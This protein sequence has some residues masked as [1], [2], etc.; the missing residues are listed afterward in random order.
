M[1]IRGA[2]DLGIRR[3]RNED[4]HAW[5][6]AADQA[7]RARRGALMVVA[8]GMGGAKSGGVASQLAVETVIRTYQEAPGVDSPGTDVVAE[9]RQSVAEANRRVHSENLKSHELSGMA[10]T[11]TA[12]VVRGPE[13]Y[14]AH[15]GDSRAYVVRDGAAHQLTED[16]SFVGML[17]SQGQISKDEARVHPR[18]NLLTRS[19]GGAPEVVIDARRCE[20]VLAPGDTLVLC[21]DGLHGLVTD[22]ELAGAA[23]GQ[24]LDRVC[25]ELIRLANHAGGDDNITVVVARVGEP[26]AGPSATR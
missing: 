22:E 7:V 23:G 10:T 9:L 24:D 14:L 26:E 6:I 13:V 20:W 12:L 15:V 2:T 1:E 19:V 11:L 18:R 16:H 4:K 8:D 3:Q 5:W 25:D 17:V 21:S